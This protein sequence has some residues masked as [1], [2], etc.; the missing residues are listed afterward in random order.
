VWAA[1]F[2]V[3]SNGLTKGALFLSAG[4][5][6]RAAGS[7]SIDEVRGMFKVMPRSSMLLV[8][9]MFAITACP[10]FGPFFSELLVLRTGFAAGQGWAMALFLTCLLLAFF[11]LSRTVFAVVDGRPRLKKM[12]KAALRESYGLILPP[13]VL[14]AA[15]LWLGLFTPDVLKEAWSAAVLQL[16]PQP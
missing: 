3:W 15:S 6:Q 5:L 10:P 7:S 16:H 8:T 9:G 1:L 11:G 13:L 12:K 2:H 14:L 4:N